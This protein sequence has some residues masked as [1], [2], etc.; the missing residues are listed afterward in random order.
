[1][2]VAAGPAA[3]GSWAP[4]AVMATLNSLFLTS[5]G[6]EMRIVCP[7]LVFF[8][9]RADATDPAVG[10]RCLHLYSR[11]VC[12][13][14]LYGCFRQRYCGIRVNGNQ[15]TR[16]T[17]FQTVSAPRNFEE[18]GETAFAVAKR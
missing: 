1:C 15:M 7:S 4:A 13:A 10:R 17:Y 16:K 3:T 11:K 2:T 14:N 12:R 9:H 8:R 18:H 5:V 6:T